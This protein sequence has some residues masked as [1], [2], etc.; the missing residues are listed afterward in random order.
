M[1]EG[2]KKITEHEYIHYILKSGTPVEKRDFLATLEGQLFL[3]EGKVWF[4]N[5]KIE[6]VTPLHVQI[7]PNTPESQE[8]GN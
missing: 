5:T 8:S 3:K 2:A 4:E 6:L 1:G 7:S